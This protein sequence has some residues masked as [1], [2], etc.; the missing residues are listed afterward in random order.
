MGKRL[1]GRK[2]IIM[3]EWERQRSIGGRVVDAVDLWKRS[4]V[5]NL[6]SFKG[7]QHTVDVSFSF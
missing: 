4:I 3:S 2:G 6:S 5:N 1:S 7:I